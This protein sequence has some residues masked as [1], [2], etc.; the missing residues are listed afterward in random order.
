MSWEA[1]SVVRKLHDSADY[2]GALAA[3]TSE[4]ESLGDVWPYAQNLEASCYEHKGDVEK[5]CAILEAADRN[6]EANFWTYYQ[7]AAIH[8]NL[9]NP[10]KS[11]ETS[12][13]AHA[14][15]GWFASKNNG[16]LF[17]HDFFSPNIP[18]WTRWFND[19]ITHTPIICGEIGSWQGGSSTWLLDQI[20]SKR[21]GKLVCFDTFEGSSEHLTW[22]DSI[23]G[24]LEE[25]F[26]HNI[27]ATGFASF[28]EKVIGDSK[29]TLRSIAPDSFDFFY[30][31]GAHEALYA[32][33]DAIL[34]WPLVRIGGFILFDD[35]DYS[36][37]NAPQRNT[38]R[39]IDAF[40]SI[41][42]EEIEIVAKGR[43]VLIRKKVPQA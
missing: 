38:K 34:V 31:D 25:L 33:Q 36:F 24:K 13:K 28:C 4:R 23:G 35:Y 39:A 37:P 20:V 5:A 7:L 41:F 22:L 14:A 40:T 18:D 26:D 3:I 9:R 29:M 12:Y 11:I 8:R 2:D 43:Q 27:Q 32:I 19:Y 42:E 15:V 17:T 16:Y 30:I 10:R 6:G 1:Y 21:G